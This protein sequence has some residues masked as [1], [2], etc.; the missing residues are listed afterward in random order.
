MNLY[1]LSISSM[2]GLES[3]MNAISFIISFSILP[4]V[5]VTCIFLSSSLIKFITQNL[6]DG[7]VYHV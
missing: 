1:S 4:V 3:L 6:L 7:L 2:N 5:D